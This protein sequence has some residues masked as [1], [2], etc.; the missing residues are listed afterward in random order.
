MFNAQQVH[1]ENSSAAAYNV[2]ITL[3]LM[4]T[5]DTEHIKQGEAGEGDKPSPLWAQ[6]RWVEACI[7][8][9]SS[10]LLT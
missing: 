5:T 2:A 7:R 8:L 4:A 3:Y 9:H 1:D 6:G 10:T